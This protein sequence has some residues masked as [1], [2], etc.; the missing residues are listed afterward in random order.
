MIRNVVLELSAKRAAK[1]ALRA[2]RAILLQK[3]VSHSPLSSLLSLRYR[4]P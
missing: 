3:F 4:L 2:C 1:M